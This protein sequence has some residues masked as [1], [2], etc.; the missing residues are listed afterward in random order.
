MLWPSR[1]SSKINTIIWLYVFFQTHTLNI[2]CNYTLLNV[3]IKSPMFFCFWTVNCKPEPKSPKPFCP[4]LDSSFL[5][6][7]LNL[8]PD[9]SSRILPC[10][11]RR[12]GFSCSDTGTAWSFL[13]FQSW[14]LLVFIVYFPSPGTGV[15]KV[16][17]S[18]Y[19][20]FLL[21]LLSHFA[22]CQ[23]NTPFF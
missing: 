5:D 2:F 12:S 9:R 1:G 22:L 18:S 20:L 23:H 7:V 19:L 6:A 4:W 13:S 8:N 17:I 14:T 11:T 16:S 21:A 10:Y 15:V 3:I